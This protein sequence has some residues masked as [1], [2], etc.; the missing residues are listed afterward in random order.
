MLTIWTLKKFSWILNLQKFISDLLE[1]HHNECQ[2][3][4]LGRS[5]RHLVDAGDLGARGIPIL[6]IYA[7]TQDNL[8]VP[9]MLELLA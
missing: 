5:P 7:R 4:G 1:D 9:T 3:E 6:D 2:T 8:V